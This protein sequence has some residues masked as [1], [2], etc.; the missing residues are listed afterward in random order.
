M[1]NGF[2]IGDRIAPQTTQINSSA[3]ELYVN[4]AERKAGEPFTTRLSQ[5][6]T[7]YLKVTSDGILEGLMK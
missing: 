2:F 6:V 5:G 4:Y 7:K 1:T 3:K